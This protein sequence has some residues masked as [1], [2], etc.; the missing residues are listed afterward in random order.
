MET[1][2]VNIR[3]VWIQPVEIEADSPEEALAMVSN[4]GG[5]YVDNGLEYS[6]TLDNDKWSVDLPDGGTWYPGGGIL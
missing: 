4:G 2:Y 6:D 1:Y 5:L 3:E